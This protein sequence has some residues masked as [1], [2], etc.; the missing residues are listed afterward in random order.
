MPPSLN[1]TFYQVKIRFFTAQ[2]LPIMDYGVAL[3][4]R[5]AKTDAFL[6]TKYKTKTLRTDV[7]IYK[8]DNPEIHWY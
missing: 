1:P 2:K 6:E 5:E 8:E 3:I 7:Q 4:G